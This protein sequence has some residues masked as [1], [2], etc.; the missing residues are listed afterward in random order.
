MP[1]RKE[2]SWGQLRVGLTVGA[3]IIVMMVGIFLVS[4]EVG[5]LG[6]HYTLKA[7]FPGAEGLRTGSEVD[8][9]GIPVGNVSRIDLSSSTDPNRAV[10]V[11]MKLQRKYMGN[12]RS[13]SVADVETAGLL[14]QSFVNISR[15]SAAEAAIGNEGVI[16]GSAGTDIKA[17]T[18]NANDVLVNLKA[19]SDQLDQISKQI[20]SG[21]GSIG[22]FIYDPT[23][24][25]RFNDIEGKMEALMNGI[26]K[27]QGTV[28]ELFTSD[29]LAN[30][31]NSTLDRMN[32]LLDQAQHGNGTLAKV[33]ND[34]SVYN[35]F[36]SGITELRTML[37][38]IPQGKGSLGQLYANRQLYD[39]VNDIAENLDTISNRMVKGQGS[40]GL[41]ST[42]SQLYDNLTQSAKTLREFLAEFRKNPK[43]YL[44]LHL[45]IF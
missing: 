17:V 11:V 45:R 2:L 1:Q 34:P 40:L 3:G 18:N 21:K 42:N 12:I 26:S 5:V 38:Q 23:L 30:K 6:G 22:K 19:V 24:F 4:G 32:Q 8:L 36:N 9:A 39:R 44:T 15:G 13:D 7:Y 28:G 31:M 16:R 33:L 41:L 37:T 35:N 20:T 29:T 43:K 27:G 10:V 25:N 14:G